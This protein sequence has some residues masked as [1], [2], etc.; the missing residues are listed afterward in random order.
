MKNFWFLFAAYTV[1]W[2][3]ILGYVL[4]LYLRERSLHREVEALKQLLDRRERQSRPGEHG[5]GS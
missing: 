3:V 4:S 5:D 2:A 1:I